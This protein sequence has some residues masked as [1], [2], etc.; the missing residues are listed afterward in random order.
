M[1]FSTH[2]PLYING[3]RSIILETSQGYENKIS[4]SEVLPFNIFAPEILTNNRVRG[5]IVRLFNEK[6]DVWAFGQLVHDAYSFNQSRNLTH[7]SSF[8]ALKHFY[9]NEI[10]RNP[11]GS[12]ADHLNGIIFES[13]IIEEVLFHC[14]MIDPVK[15]FRFDLLAKRLEILHQ[16]ILHVFHVFLIIFLYLEY[17]T[18][19]STSSI[20]YSPVSPT[21]S[22]FTTVEVLS[23]EPGTACSYRRQLLRKRPSIDSCWSTSTVETY[24]TF[25]DSNTALTPRSP[26]FKFPD[27]IYKNCSQAPPTPSNHYKNIGVEAEPLDLY[28]TADNIPLIPLKL[29]PVPK[30]RPWRV[31][32]SE[33]RQGRID[34]VNGEEQPLMATIEE[35]GNF[36]Q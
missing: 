36:V 2:R 24:K 31:K 34:N 19:M 1:P 26:G 30:K 12:I 20:E 32:K 33:S 14:L 8:L 16:S 27:S 4:D 15:R 25:S 5:E 10:N 29:Q 9:D 6:T 11:N 17:K 18:E 22:N 13:N 28:L 3:Y 23:S 21:D 7:F 35:N